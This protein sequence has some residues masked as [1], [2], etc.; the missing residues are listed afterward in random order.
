MLQLSGHAGRNNDQSLCVFYYNSKLKVKD[1]VTRIR[2]IIE[3]L[4]PNYKKGGR[5]KSSTQNGHKN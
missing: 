2:R 5:I 4:Y 1:A 3:K